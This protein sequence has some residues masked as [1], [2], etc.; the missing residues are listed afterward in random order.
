[1][2]SDPDRG[3][4]ED[5][6]A[7]RSE[8]DD[9][10]QLVHELHEARPASWLAYPGVVVGAAGLRRNLAQVLGGPGVR[11]DPEPHGLVAENDPA[12]LQAR[13]GLGYVAAVVL[14]VREQH[15][16]PVRRS[17]VAVPL[18]V[19]IGEEQGVRHGRPAVPDLH[20][21]AAG[22]D[23]QCP[24]GSLAGLGSIDGI[25]KAKLNNYGQELLALLARPRS[26][27]DSSRGDA[28]DQG[29]DS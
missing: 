26:E 18:H 10:G 22:R 14:A 16:H 25:G 19:A 15:D 2:A 11:G 9:H 17:G 21:Q 8:H 13:H 3:G 24:P 23:G 27:P 28:A 6:P 4:P 1:M 7:E 29:R 12:G 20:Q 5:S